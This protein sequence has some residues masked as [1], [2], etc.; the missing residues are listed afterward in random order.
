MCYELNLNMI[1]I[2]FSSLQDTPKDKYGNYKDPD[3][4]SKKLREYHMFL[5]SKH[6]DKRLMFLLN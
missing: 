5:W 4:H 3:R 6:I 2:K 1:D